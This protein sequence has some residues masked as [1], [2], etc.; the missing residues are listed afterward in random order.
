MKKIILLSLAMFCIAYSQ[1]TT[2]N[3]DLPQWNVGD[4]L[5]V[6][7]KNDT[8]RANLGLNSA[9]SR[10]DA[11]V[12]RYIKRDG[13]F[14]GI[15]GYGS[16][17][18][19]INAGTASAT[20]VRVTISDSLLVSY[21]ATFEK[22][23]LI[24]QNLFVGG[25]ITADSIIT[26]GGDFTV[27]NGLSVLGN[28]GIT[29][30]GSSGINA[31]YDITSLRSLKSGVAGGLSGSLHLESSGSSGEPS[32]MTLTTV[33]T[34]YN[35]TLYLPH[36]TGANRIDTLITANGNQNISDIGYVV[37]DS[38][39][40]TNVFSVLYSDTKIAGSSA[41]DTSANFTT[42]INT[43]NGNETKV[44]LTY[45]HRSGVKYI[46]ATYQIKGAVTA[47]VGS[48][49]KI[50]T[51]AGVQVLTN[52]ETSNA[53]ATFATDTNTLD[54]S[55]LTN[56]TLYQLRFVT[57]GTTPVDDIPTTQNLVILSTTN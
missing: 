3:L 57:Y 46:K 52:S 32:G 49:L 11:I 23:M 21:N 22:S 13:K 43:T 56:G 30:Y 50:F 7:T 19:D 27:Y 47:T 54:V 28:S 29:A 8:T 34:D 40:S 5:K 6:R 39:F 2:S 4:T 10:L 41:G 20:P 51:I 42:F 45:L 37:A 36:K 38:I 26:S 55:G 15:G 53:N 25:Y 16:G 44:R 12:G 24:T 33:G 1:T 48:M 35:D 18:L 14:S 31:V 9:F 17:N